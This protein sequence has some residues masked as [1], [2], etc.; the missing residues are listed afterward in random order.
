MQVPR[1]LTAAHAWELVRYALVGGLNTLTYFGLY[2]AGVLAGVPYILAALGA[3]VL[4]ASVG[5]WLHEHWT[6]GGASPTAH[7]LGKWLATQGVAVGANIALLAIAVGY[8]DADEI[9]AQLVLIPV[10][11]AAT[12][13]IGRRFVFTHAAGRGRAPA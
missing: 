5:Y 7:A 2:S 13:V 8:L 3:F 9:L 6:F 10:M 4:S 11:P 1:R 12:Y